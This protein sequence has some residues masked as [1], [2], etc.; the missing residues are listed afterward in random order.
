MH[1]NDTVLM[2]PTVSADPSVSSRLQQ[3]CTV[4]LDSAEWQTD[5]ND[6]SNW[7]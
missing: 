5:C 7:I 3:A 4:L 6:L 2:H 1:G